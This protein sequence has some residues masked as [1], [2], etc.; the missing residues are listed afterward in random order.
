MMNVLID[1]INQHEVIYDAEL[2]EL[3]RKHN[4][5]PDSPELVSNL[6]NLGWDHQMLVAKDCTS[7][8]EDRPGIVRYN[9]ER[10][11]TNLF[12]LLYA[13]TDKGATS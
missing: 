13:L 4:V 10:Q 12:R 2:N 3:C 8:H 9:K 11:K 6:V 5:D 7:V 1:E